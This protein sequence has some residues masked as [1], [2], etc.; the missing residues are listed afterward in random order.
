MTIT[1]LDKAEAGKILPELYRIFHDNMSRILDTA[2]PFPGGRDGW[3]AAVGPA[4]DKV[5]R[6]IL[7]LC[8]GEKI[9]GFFQYYVNDG[10]FMMEEIQF[11]EEYRGTGLFK[12]LYRYLAGIIPEE[13]EYVEAY[14]HKTNRKSMAVLNHLGLT[15]VE[16]DP[17]ESLL[18][19][20]G[21]YESLV[22]RYGSD[23]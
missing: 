12:K 1:F 21:R 9:A 14:V 6:Q 5:P 18:H 15:A 19:F 16:E 11:R 2:E 17:N 20:R 3:L 13:T 10:V 23:I 22:C 4:L 8:D 7:L